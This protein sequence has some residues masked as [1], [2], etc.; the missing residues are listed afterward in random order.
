MIPEIPKY[1][2]KPEMYAFGTCAYS[3][4]RDIAVRFQHDA[5]I[6]M[7]RAFD[8]LYNMRRYECSPLFRMWKRVHSMEMTEVFDGLSENLRIPVPVL[9]KHLDVV[10]V[11]VRESPPDTVLSRLDYDTWLEQNH[12]TDAFVGAIATD[13]P[14][15]PPTFPDD[16]ASDH[17]EMFFDTGLGC[18]AMLQLVDSDDVPMVLPVPE[19]A[20]L[21][22]VKSAQMLMAR[23][24]IRSS[25]KL[26]IPVFVEGTKLALPISGHYADPEHMTTKIT[27]LT[28]TVELEGSR[29]ETYVVNPWSKVTQT[30]RVVKRS[31]FDMEV[32]DEL[33]VSS[34][35]LLRYTSTIEENLR[36]C[37]T[38]MLNAPFYSAVPSPWDA[39][40]D[41]CRGVILCGTIHEFQCGFTNMEMPALDRRTCMDLV[42]A[43]CES[44]VAHMAARSVATGC[45]EHAIGTVTVAYGPM[46]SHAVLY[47]SS[48]TKIGVRIRMSHVAIVSDNPV[49]FREFLRANWK[50]TWIDELKFL[51][52]ASNILRTSGPVHL[53]P[54]PGA[55][56]YYRDTFTAS[57]ISKKLWRLVGCGCDYCMP[58]RPAILN[59]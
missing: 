49:E 57:Y 9:Q 50:D 51:T 3:M 17:T 2:Q 19:G 44:H 32:I 12:Y 35:Q 27:M 18:L 26:K 14:E 59:A 25:P 34:V 1:S 52:A 47:I 43:T 4:A 13:C 6:D 39:I 20:G 55:R 7:V 53:V 11:F 41:L 31:E 38:S 46:G 28:V 23:W 8:L 40:S 24:R 42:R 36:L 10:G 15:R 16:D 56:P 33:G 37:W 29:T 54:V 21:G 58:R 5:P 22:V 30:P 45:G 48:I